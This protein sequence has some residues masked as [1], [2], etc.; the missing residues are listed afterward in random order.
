MADFSCTG[1]F[2]PNM[3]TAHVTIRKRWWRDPEYWVRCWD[4]DLHIG[5]FTDRK[6]AQLAWAFVERGQMQAA[7]NLAKGV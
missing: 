7:F 4:C 1:E 3:H 5:P 6:T 2:G